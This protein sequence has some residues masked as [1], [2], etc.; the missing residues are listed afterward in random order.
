MGRHV[1]FR[2]RFAQRRDFGGGLAEVIGRT[3]E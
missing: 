2:S 3:S 1:L